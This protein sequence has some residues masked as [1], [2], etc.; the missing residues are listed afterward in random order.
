MMTF[1]A[2]E[3]KLSPWHIGSLGLIAAW[4]L[5]LGYLEVFQP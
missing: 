3:M 1:S 5:I 2:G 4:L